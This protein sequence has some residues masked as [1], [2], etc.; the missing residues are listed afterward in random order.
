MFDDRIEVRSPGKLPGPIKAKK[1]LG[2]DKIHYSRNPLMARVLTDAGFMRSL[3]DGLPRIFQE[4]EQ[5]GL[6]PPEWKEEETF[7]CL[8][9][10]NT[11]ILDE[12]TLAWL[13][14]FSDYPL[15]PR[16]KRILTYARVHGGIFSSSDYQKFGVDRDGAYTEIKDLVRQGIVES[17][18]KRGK[19]Y[20]IREAKEG[21]GMPGL[22]WAMEALREKG[23]FTLRELKVPRSVSRQRVQ[24]II[25]SLSREGYFS[26]V[27]SGKAIRYYPT[28]KM[29]QL[30]QKAD[31]RKV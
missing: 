16:Q 18:K 5:Q 21:A 23:Y 14:R 10:R 6:N 8:V 28:E 12:D 9:F 30:L 24:G 22:S 31:G 3:G 13:K 27:G 15:N 25:R 1:I 4:M 19:V 2:R 26:P 11:P 7:F 20:R 17:F 29:N